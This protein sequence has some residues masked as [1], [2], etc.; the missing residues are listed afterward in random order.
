MSN[1]ELYEHKRS[2]T[3]KWV[4][5]LLGFILVGVMLA[6]IICGWFGKNEKPDIEDETEQAAIM[7]GNGNEMTGDSVYPISRIVAMSFCE[8]RS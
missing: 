6:G 8:P 3:V 5:T 7:D 2:D 4:I 1:K